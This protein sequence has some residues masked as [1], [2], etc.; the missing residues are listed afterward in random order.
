MICLK[1]ANKQQQLRRYNIESC[2][3]FLRVDISVTINHL[4]VLYFILFDL[5][6][7]SP[8]N[9]TKV[10]SSWTVNLLNCFQVGLDLRLSSNQYSVPVTDNCHPTLIRQL[11]PQGEKLNGHRNHFMTSLHQSCRPG[12]RTSKPRIEARLQI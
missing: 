11:L 6:F 8:V 7:Y 1:E 12:V 2:R 9:S 5:R 4:H 3:I 10:M